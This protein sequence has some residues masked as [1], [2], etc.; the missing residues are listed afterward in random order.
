[1]PV[2]DNFSPVPPS[3][4]EQITPE[5]SENEITLTLENRRYRVRGLQKNSSYDVLK[6]NLLVDVDGVVIVDTFDLYSAKHRQ[7]FIRLVASECSVD[8]KII[9]RDLGKLLLQLEGLQDQAIQET[10]KPKEPE[11][12][13]MDSAEKEHALELLRD[14]N[15]TQ[16]IINDFTVTGLVG[17]PTNALMGWLTNKDVLMLRAQDTQEQ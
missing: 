3:P 12:Y 16:K 5:I 10:L 15:L 8:E 2:P 17:E 14:K 7:Q 13:A 11:P 4:Q 9:Q 1:M 6:I